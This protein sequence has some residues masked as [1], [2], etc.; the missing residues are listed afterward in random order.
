MTREP[1]VVGMLDIINAEREKSHSLKACRKATVRRVDPTKERK[2]FHDIS[3]SRT[4]SGIS[5]FV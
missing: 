3:R 5:S 4:S 1:V 2:Q